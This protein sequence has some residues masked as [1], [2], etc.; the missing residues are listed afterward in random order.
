[1]TR[2]ALALLLTA[3]APAVLVGAAQAQTQ[4]AQTDTPASP[5]PSTAAPGAS[6]VP[7]ADAP[8]A[9]PAAVADQG[10][11]PTSGQLDANAQAQGALVYRPE[12]FAASRPSTALDMIT[13]LPGFQL[14]S[15]N[16]ARGFAGTAGNVLIDG[17]RP[18]SKS[19]TVDSIVSR[20]PA[21]QVERIEVIRGGAPGIDMQGQSVVAN[22]I[23]RSGNASQQTLTIAAVTNLQNGHFDSSFRYEAS[24][25]AGPRSAEISFGRGINSSDSIGRG[26]RVRRD[27][28]GSVTRSELSANEADGGYGNVKGSVKTPLFGGEFRANATLTKSDFKDEEHFTRVDRPAPTNDIVETSDT[29]RGE[30]GGNYTRPLTARLAVEVVG[31]QKL[32]K[33]EAGAVDE[34]GADRG[35][36]TSDSTSGETIA[37]GILRL[38]RSD[39]LSF[40]G[41]GEA[42]FN[43]RDGHTAFND[44]GVDVP[45]PSS[46]VRVEERRA[47]AFVTATWRPLPALG[48]EA[49]SRFESSTISQSGDSSLERSFFYPKPR[50]LL[51]W[52]PRPSDTFRLRVEREVGQLNFG[53]FVASANLTDDR[54]V[55]GNAELEPDKTWV[56]EVSAERRFW[57]SGSIGVS[58]A[59]EQITDA[60]DRLPIRVRP[61]PD[62]DPNAPDI[63]FDAPGNIGDGSQT[64][65]DVNLTL[66]LGRFGVP[67]GELKVSYE[68]VDSE[69]TDPT[70]GEA[71]RISGQRPINARA[72]FRQDLPRW[73]LTYGVD[74]LHGFDEV[75]YRFNE[76]T[77][78]SIDRYFGLFAEYK[79]SARTSI[80]VEVN[81]AG[82]YFLERERTVFDG[83]RD[84]A[85]V[86]F[87]EDYDTRTQQTAFIRLRR[88]LR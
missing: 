12:F 64:E 9:T 33:S 10:A 6:A 16:S 19:D 86:R 24:R 81:N 45:L 67:G 41:G 13:R 72:S 73:K 53:D 44:N 74:Y 57:E 87:T 63:V 70:T 18:A 77:R 65:L 1:M 51:T 29:L 82:R 3:A 80:R 75:Y 43:F 37:R 36:F 14:D 46:D 31:L 32:S 21:S 47:E 66:P 60:I 69:V 30:I 27:A 48:L 58:L 54:I 71:R 8:H 55:A 4:P 85:G 78:V 38:K 25:T 50:L 56:I 68:V 28:S 26:S 83:P 79:P 20:I 62:L 76:I 7:S 11:T 61:N 42:A 17:K 49:G 35:V 40:E 2:A 15:G 88:T 52:T 23:L 39:T 22:V 84:R 59:R 5:V 34:Q